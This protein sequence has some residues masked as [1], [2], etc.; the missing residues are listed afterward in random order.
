MPFETA[1]T[2]EHIVNQLDILTQ[3]V[4]ILEERLT[5]VEDRVAPRPRGP[6]Q[7]AAVRSNAGQVDV[8]LRPAN[9]AGSA[10]ASGR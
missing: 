3:T 9:S 4:S 7:S 2:L 10:G 8:E 6:A 1:S 5:F